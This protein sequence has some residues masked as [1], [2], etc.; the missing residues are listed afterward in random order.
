MAT[1]E[2]G[3]TD[4]IGKIDRIDGD[5]AN[6]AEPANVTHAFAV[7]RAGLDG[8]VVN[9][10]LTLISIIQGVALYFLTDS[11]RG[12]LVTLQWPYLPYVLTGLFVILLWWSRAVIHTLT[13]IHWPIEFIHNFLYVASTLVQATMF[14]QVNNPANW[15]LL[16]AG[17]AALLW[18]LFVSDLRLIRERRRGQN[19]PVA[20]S[21]FNTLYREQRFHARIS[22]PLSVLFYAGAAL[23]IRTWPHFFLDANG[24]VVLAL[25]QLTGAITYVVYIVLFFHRI[26]ARIL[27]MREQAQ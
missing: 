20:Q 10:E 18:L 2:P 17:Y 26:S 1:Y 23:A 27:V 8:M 4:R 9:L 22:M 21:L 25:L 16:G 6:E 3:G 14:T 11:S 15:F 5:E 13:V 12:L 24:H 19:S 7:S